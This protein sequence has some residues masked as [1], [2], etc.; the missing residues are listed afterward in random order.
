[1]TYEFEDP[2]KIKVSLGN[3]YKGFST[4]LESDYS[5]E[6]E[7]FENFSSDLP[8]FNDGVANSKDELPWGVAA[9]WQG[10]DYTAVGADPKGKYYEK[11]QITD[12]TWSVGAGISKF[13][14]KNG[15]LDANGNED[16]NAGVDK[17]AIVIDSGV[18][19]LSDF[20]IGSISKDLSYS[21]V[22][23]NY[24]G[25]LDTE[26]PFKDNNGHGTHVAGTIAAKAD[27]KGVVGVAPGAEIISM[28]VFGKSGSTTIDTI[29][30]AVEQSIDYIQK[31]SVT[32]KGKTVDTS[33]LNFDNTVINM[34]LGGG[35]YQPLITMVDNAATSGVNFLL[36]REI[37]IKMLIVFLLRQLVIMQ[38]FI[39]YLRSI[40]NIKWHHS[41][42]GMIQQAL[43]TLIFL[44]LE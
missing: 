44:L 19:E 32:V 41:Q 4:Q 13:L 43:M 42:T 24:D 38:M 33:M 8:L 6:T 14:L 7:F 21:F 10:V 11:A 22:D 27:G 34:S 1:M 25:I 2:S 23:T 31:D 36:P 12:S 9:V 29:M 17:F 5:F 30:N 3:V 28:K 37:Q 18:N 15:G 35:Y 26:D 39:Q 16:K 20:N 40:R